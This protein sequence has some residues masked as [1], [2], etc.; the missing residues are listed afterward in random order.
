MSIG[1]RI[2][3]GYDPERICIAVIGSHSALQILAGAKREGLCTVLLVR[4]DLAPLYERF[5]W[6]YDYMLKL[7]SWSEIASGTIVEKLRSLNAILVPHAGLVEYVGVERAEKLEVPIHGNRGLFRIE[8]DQHSK[9]RLLVDAGIPTPRVYGSPEEVDGLVIVKMPGAK[10]GRGYFLAS[11]PEEVRRGLERAVREGLIRDPRE[12]IIQEYVVGV[13][14]YYHYY[15]SRLYRRVELTGMDIRY[16]SNVDGL[17]RLPPRF[18]ESLEPSFVVVGNI[19]M[20]LRERLLLKVLEYGEAFA[21]T[22][23][24]ATGLPMMGPYSLESIVT[25]SLEIRVFEFSGR[26]VAGTNLYTGM[27]SPYTW[28]YWDEPMW[29]GRRIAREVREAALQGRLEEVVT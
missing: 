1:S 24:Q 4:E 14:A 5:P 28:L 15:A 16:E 9:M 11:S 29:P 18:A 3:S 23:E 19:P 20:V 2:V 8:A 26:I 27:G 6:L 21:R 17:R 10:G 25:P 13:P 22:V 7:R 12:A